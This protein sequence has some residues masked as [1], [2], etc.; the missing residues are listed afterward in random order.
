MIAVEQSPKGFGVLNTQRRAGEI[1]GCDYSH[2]FKYVVH[3][4]ALS[5]AD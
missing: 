5:I 4:P 1:E 3:R 2:G